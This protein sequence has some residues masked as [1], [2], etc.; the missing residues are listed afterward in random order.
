MMTGLLVSLF[1][2][3]TILAMTQD[4]TYPCFTHHGRLSS[5]NGITIRIWLIG[6]KRSVGVDGELP[7]A[8][9]DLED[10]YLSLTSQQHSY[11]F[12]DFTM[13]PTGPDIPG[14]MRFVRLTAATN[15]VV[16]D[17]NRQRPPFKVVSTWKSRRF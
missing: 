4:A 17:I 5:Q 6:T 3:A 7:Q 15:L 11:I 16:Q 12:G 9:K 13:C 1:L 2:N 10:P 8:I 14:H